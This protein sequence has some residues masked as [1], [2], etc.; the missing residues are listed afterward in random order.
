M[1]QR[2]T[3]EVGAFGKIPWLSQVEQR[4]N[5]CTLHPMH[6]FKFY[7]VESAT[8]THSRIGTIQQQSVIRG[9]CATQSCPSQ[10][11]YAIQALMC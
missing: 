8:E 11:A 5:K 3:E 4:S 2:T 7:Q 9:R 1:Q 6:S 10:Y